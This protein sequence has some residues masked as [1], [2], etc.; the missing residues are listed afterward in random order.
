LTFL[1]KQSLQK[2]NDRLWQEK[3][4]IIFFAGHSN[5]EPNGQDGRIYINDTESLTID[6]LSNGL[7]NAIK[8][9]LK[10]AIFNSC[11]GMGLARSL[12]KLNIPQVIVMRERVPDLVAQEFLRYFLIDFAAGTSLYQSVRRARERL[13]G[14]QNKY[15]C[16]TWLPI[17]CQNPAE[18][19]LTWRRGWKKYVRILCIILL[20][21]L[22]G[23]IGLWWLHTQCKLP[24]Q[25]CPKIDI[26]GSST[27]TQTNIEN[28]NHFSLGDRILVTANTNS[29]KQNGVEAFA[30]GDYKTAIIS[31]QAAL[32]TKRNDPETLIYL[33]NAKAAITGRT[34]RIAVRVPIGSNLNIAQEIL[35]GAAQAQEEFN[36][37][38]GI[39]G[40]LI[41]VIIAND[42][43]KPETAKQVAA[44]LV[45]D[46]KV[47]GVVGHNASEA[48]IAAAPIYQAGRLVM[49]SPTSSVLELSNTG[50]Y[51]FRTAPSNRVDA[52]KIVHYA[53]KN[54]HKSRFAICIDSK[55]SF[56]TSIK[57]EL[58]NAVIDSGGHLSTIPCDLSD[59]NFNPSKFIPDAISDRVDA[60][61]LI[62]SVDKIAEAIN[63][64]KA[65]KRRIA[66]FGGSTMYTFDTLQKGQADTLGMVLA[67]VWHPLAQP[68]SIFA[69]SAERLWGAPVNWRTAT[70]YDAAQ[71]IIAALRQDSSRDGV[72]KVISNPNFKVVD[73]AT[74]EF[75]F[76]PTGDRKRTP[77]NDILIQVQIFPNNPT[78]YGFVPIK[79]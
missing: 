32:R 18:T 70:S 55:S 34:L 40:T 12:F 7:R 19:P 51:I 29:D 37:R 41:E 58:N 11:D 33:N 10:L 3:W 48:S 6:E 5:S 39:N 4:D 13:Q 46:S 65:N 42:D 64:V 50:N 67:V 59:P 44:G 17:I 54:A 24:L 14:L 49:I 22:P 79:L 20:F 68:E 60:L 43:N 47:L 77:Q 61:V 25:V 31:F 21:L 36:S 66:L 78:G 2:I 73:G 63:L 1:V 76:L 23:G 57:T 52:Q 71:A 35:R 53:I 27:G 15:P 16:A 72:Q 8:N 75:V 28:A 45:K 69:K 56:S 9:G 30:K 62:P 74:G 38:G 26:S